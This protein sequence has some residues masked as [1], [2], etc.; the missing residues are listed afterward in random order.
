MGGVEKKLRCVEGY[1]H[2]NGYPGRGGV[3]GDAV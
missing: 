3:H 2:R 1:N